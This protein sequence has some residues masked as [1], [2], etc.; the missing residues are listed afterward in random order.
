MGFSMF[1]LVSIAKLLH[2]GVKREQQ[3]R[4]IQLMAT[5]L[6]D[7]AQ[8]FSGFSKISPS[9]DLE[10]FGKYPQPFSSDKN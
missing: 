6:F 1:N 5:K 9:P 2:L 3:V 8:P 7:N 10:R 4:H